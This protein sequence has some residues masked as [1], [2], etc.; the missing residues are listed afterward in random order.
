MRRNWALETWERQHLAVPDNEI[1]ALDAR[2][3]TLA[4]TRNRLVNRGVSVG[5]RRRR[6]L[7]PIMESVSP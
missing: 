5:T 1:A 6:P 3:L 7:S 4:A 2:R